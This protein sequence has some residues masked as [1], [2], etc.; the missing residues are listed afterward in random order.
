M[1]IMDRQAKLRDIDQVIVRGRFKDDW[2]SLAQFQVPAWY[3]QAKFGIFIHWGV[4]AV[5]AFNNE[6]YPRNMYIH[7]TAEYEHHLKTY[8]PHKEFGYKDF[9]PLF[10]A[11]KFDPDA[12]AALFAEA[13]A[14]YV[15]PVAEH[16]DGF[17]MYK[18]DLSEWNA[19]E[20]GPCRDT[21]AELKAAFE[22]KGLVTGVSSHR[23]EH[24]FFLGH[25]R[26]FDSDIH[27]PLQ[28]GDL[29][30]PSMPEP[31]D[32]ND[33][34]GQPAPSAEYLEDWLLRSCELVDRF[35][36]RVFYFDW[37]ILHRA[38]QPYLKKFA[39]YYYNRAEELGYD[40]A[41]DYKV[42]SFAFG[43]AVPDME[44]GH[45]AQVQPYFWQTDTAIAYNSWCYTEQNQYKTPRDII[46]T[47][48]DVVSKNGSLLLNVGPKADGTI[49]PEDTAV[50]QG[51]GKWLR[52]N[53]EA[54][55]GSTPW[56]VAEEGPT[57]EADGQFSEGSAKAYTAQDI[58]FTAANGCLYAT[59]LAFPEDGCVTVRSLAA[60]AEGKPALTLAPIRDV[61][62]LGWDQAPEWSRDSEGLHIRA[63]FVHSDMPVVFR[64]SLP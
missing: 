21:T 41:I 39:A 15:I 8:G 24:W 16:H 18:S 52:T 42:D 6:W 47:L 23:I 33:V 51:I 58:R 25:G 49:G 5:P 10:K 19:A 59:V 48:V 45:F 12:W 37:W 20:K 64:V 50:L 63:P 26:E 38:A 17:Q 44:R 1:N 60:P 13:G 57:K 28:V 43:A 31:K 14:R 61:K 27:E 11:E 7:G 55:Y 29:Y 32:F 2:A 56:R 4:Y 3:R 62:A 9:I 46:L 53:G 54:I 30:W 35:Q 40:A 22:K 36:P 34:N